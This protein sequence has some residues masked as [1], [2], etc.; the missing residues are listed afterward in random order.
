[1]KAGFREA[2]TEQLQ[3]C[4]VWQGSAKQTV[5]SGTYR[6]SAISG[7]HLVILNKGRRNAPDTLLCRVV[8]DDGPTD[9]GGYSAYEV[10]RLSRIRSAVWI[11]PLESRDPAAGV[12]RRSWN[13]S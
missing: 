6:R 12:L 11:W 3:T 5:I 7:G 13:T 1:G 2:C 4:L 10:L 8:H 9:N